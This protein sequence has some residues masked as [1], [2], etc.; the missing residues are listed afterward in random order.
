MKWSMENATVPI[1]GLNTFVFEDGANLAIATSP[2]EQ[3]EVAGNFAVQ[4][5]KNGV[6]SP[7][8]KTKQFIVGVDEASTLPGGQFSKLPK[9]YSAYALYS[10]TFRTVQKS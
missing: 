2:Y 10:R 4:I 9:T 5:I 8:T 1:I 3:G 7:H 6:L